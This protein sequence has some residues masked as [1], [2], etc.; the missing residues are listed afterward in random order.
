MEPQ[1]MSSKNL[2]EEYG[3]FISGAEHLP[4]GDGKSL[5]YMTAHKYRDELLVRLEQAGKDRA[6]IL[7]IKRLLYD[8]Y[9]LSLHSEMF[10]DIDGCCV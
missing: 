9:S 10:Q 6:A 2:I 7:K 3:N 4:I 1:E 8:K 5:T